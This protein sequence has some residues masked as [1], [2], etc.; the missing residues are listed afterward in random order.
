MAAGK[1]AEEYM[2]A[3]AKGLDDKMVEIFTKAGVE[4]VTMNAEQAQA[5]LEEGDPFA[6]MRTDAEDAAAAAD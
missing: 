3:Q 1:K 5:I 2:T 4:V 6:T